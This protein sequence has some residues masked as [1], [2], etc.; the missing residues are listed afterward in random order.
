MLDSGHA[1]AVALLFFQYATAGAGAFTL[2]WIPRDP[3]TG[4]ALATLSLPL[5]LRT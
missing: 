1:A 3:E 5:G 4:Q 2:S